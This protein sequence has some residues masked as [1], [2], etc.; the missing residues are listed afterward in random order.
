[1]R[2][3][4]KQPISFDLKQKLIGSLPLLLFARLIN[5]LLF[6][7]WFKSHLTL[8]DS[9]YGL[10]LISSFRRMFSGDAF[11]RIPCQPIPRF[12]R[13][14][15]IIRVCLCFRWFDGNVPRD[16]EIDKRESEEKTK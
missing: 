10:T 8:D 15:T 9:L 16:T 5:K 1:M 7:E 13:E 12:G 11:A 6:L 3:I 4:F 14:T 2:I